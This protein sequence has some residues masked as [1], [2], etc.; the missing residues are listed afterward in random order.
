LNIII[1][2]SEL[3]NTNILTAIKAA[4]AAGL[5]DGARQAE[6]IAK[7]HAEHDLVVTGY[8]GSP[9]TI[10][11]RNGARKPR[12]AARKAAVAPKASKAP[13]GHRGVKKATA[14]REKGVKE[15]IA[16][17]IRSAAAGVTVA[18][19]VADTGF[20]TTSVRRTL[21]ALKRAGIAMHDNKLWSSAP[22]AAP[23][24]GN[25]EAEAHA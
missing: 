22:T 19:I 3:M 23:N 9:I 11:P 7:L 25:A 6:I 24:S 16:D 2:R 13:K 10:T 18:Q 17:Y 5:A 14:P 15:G 8:A 12:G 4:Y 1:T 21:M 20:K